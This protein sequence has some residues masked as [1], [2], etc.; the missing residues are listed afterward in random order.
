MGAGGRRSKKKLHKQGKMKQNTAGGNLVMDYNPSRIL[1]GTLCYL[2]EQKIPDYLYF[3]AP[4][5]IL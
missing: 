3:K 1:L 2:Y 4:N 5:L